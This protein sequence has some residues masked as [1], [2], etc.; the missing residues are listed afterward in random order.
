MEFAVF[1]PIVSIIATA[2]VIVAV[3][4]ARQGK[5]NLGPGTSMSVGEAR[6]NV[7][8]ARENEDLKLTIERLEDRLAVL[9]R[10][11]TDP[12]ERTAREIERLR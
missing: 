8:L 12:A 1:I 5:G 6:E 2:W 9:E 11:A 4:R 10:I 3:A 7:Q